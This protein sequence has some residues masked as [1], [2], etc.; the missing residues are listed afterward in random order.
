VARRHAER[1]EYLSNVILAQH[2]INK[3]QFDSARDILLNESQA[4]YRGWEWGRLQYQC[5]LD[6]LTLRGHSGWV[7]RLAFNPDGTRL[8]S[9]GGDDATVRVW[10][11]EAGRALFVA[12][13]TNGVHALAFSPDGNEIATGSAF[14]E[15]LQLWDART[16]QRR[17]AFAHGHRGR[18]GTL[19][20]VA[21]SSDG[22]HL[23][24]GGG[25]HV[26]RLWERESG[27]VLRTFVG[28]GD[29]ILTIALS[30]DGKRLVTAGGDPWV[31]AKALDCTIR[32]WDVATARE[33]LRLTGHRQTVFSVALSPD[34]RR[35]VSGGGDQT[36]RQWDLES[37]REIRRL[38]ESSDLI[39]GV[40]YSPDGRRVVVGGWDKCVRVFDADTG[41][42]STAL[43]GHG[44]GVYSVVFSPD[45]GQIASSGWDGTIKLWEAA[46][47]PD[48]PILHGHEQAVWS[49]AFSRDEKRMATGSWDKTAKVWD[50]VDGRLLCRLPVGV[51]V[52]GIAFHP[53]ASRLVTVGENGSARI[54]DVANDSACVAMELVGHSNSVLC[55][56]Y[57]PDG[58]RIA[59]GSRDGTARMWDASTGQQLLELQAHPD[60]WS[61][62]FDPAGT[63]LATAGS[64]RKARIWE[65]TS[66]GELLALTGHG[67]EVLCVAFS[68]DGRRLA[69]GGGGFD[70][71]VRLWDSRTGELLRV[72]KGHWDGYQA[73]VKAIAFSPDGQRLATAGGGTEVL[74]PKNRDHSAK[75]WDIESG[76]ELLS[77]EGHSNVVYSVAFS[78]DGRGLA[79]AG[80]GTVIFWEAFPWKPEDYP[81]GKELPFAER[82][83]CYKRQ[84]WTNHSATG[85]PSVRPA[86]ASNE[87]P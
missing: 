45:G 73:G 36:I 66:G 78:P 11:L 13:Q 83:E 38:G 72:F 29:A 87:S 30:L 15:A 5:N 57:S 23:F 58:R 27:R 1:G 65:V 21:Y 3:R 81:G 77:L 40:A 14:G 9:T 52:L 82:L 76:R 54:W 28:H 51:P 4:A 53:T 63:R 20:A 31:Y 6:R 55:V 61:V 80:V 24:T 47:A 17:Q 32:I 79:T 18:H 16:G 71:T 41:R 43:R 33:L 37:G 56:A 62:A 2:Y 22:K 75:I 46:P 86:T 70:G 26:V 35:L 44:Q 69:T 68:P 49:V 39:F 34:G 85:A 67:A 48:P 42:E 12:R 19:S 60:I 10:D 25:D 64:D 7:T 8:A 74:E 84:Y 59:T 50:A